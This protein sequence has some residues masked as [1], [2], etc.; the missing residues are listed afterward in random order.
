MTEKPYALR[1]AWWEV[2]EA[3]NA[4]YINKDD[5]TLWTAWNAETVKFDKLL[6]KH[7]QGRATP[8][9]QSEGVY[10]GVKGED[11]MMFSYRDPL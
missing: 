5:M 10:V 2:V 3:R 8:S 6:S 9:W 4:F 11:V 7:F 1:K